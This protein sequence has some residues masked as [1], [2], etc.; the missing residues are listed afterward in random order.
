MKK[1]S[2]LIRLYSAVLLFSFIYLLSL[3]FSQVFCKSSL[4]DSYVAHKLIYGVFS[5]IIKLYQQNLKQAKVPDNYTN[6]LLKVLKTEA[7]P[8]VIKHPLLLKRG[9]YAGIHDAKAILSGNKKKAVSVASRQEVCFVLT[10]S[11][12]LS[13][14][15][16]VSLSQDLFSFLFFIYLEY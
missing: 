9:K 15:I 7:N 2:H 12:Q 14:N 10:F 5:F 11:Q 8:L 3:V 1:K 6:Q 13:L 4:P 16:Y